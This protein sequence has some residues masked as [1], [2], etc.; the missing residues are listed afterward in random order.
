MRAEGRKLELGVAA[1]SQNIRPNDPS[2]IRLP[3]PSPALGIQLALTV[4]QQVRPHGG[5]SRV[6]ETQ[7]ATMLC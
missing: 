4:S 6:G 2:Q 1:L 5:H 3:S 7:T